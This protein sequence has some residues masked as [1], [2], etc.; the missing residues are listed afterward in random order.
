MKRFMTAFLLL[1]CLIPAAQAK[2]VLDIKVPDSQTYGDTQLVLNGSGVRTKFIYDVYIIALYTQSQ[3]KDAQALITADEPMAMRIYIISDLVTGERFA[4][5][6]HEGFVRSTDGDLKN[7]QKEVDTLVNSFRNNLEKDDVYDLV[8]QPGTGVEIFRN[9]KQEDV[10]PGLEFKQ[11]LFGIWLG[12]K[13]VNTG[14][15]D[16]LLSKD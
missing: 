2:R 13:P 12:D 5:Y 10:A 11:A 16:E 15:R 9:G 7:I 1:L 4:D 14:L 8:Y 3:S 6:T